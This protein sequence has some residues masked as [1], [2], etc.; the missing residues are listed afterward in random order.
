MASGSPSR[1]PDTSTS[2]TTT[3]GTPLA[4]ATSV[5]VET[6]NMRSSRSGNPG[7]GWRRCHLHRDFCHHPLSAVT[8]SGT[9][10]RFATGQKFFELPSAAE[11]HVGGG[12]AH[13]L[14][15]D[16]LHAVEVG[17]EVVRRHDHVGVERLVV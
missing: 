4:G 14:H 17:I 7:G 12:A 1:K 6:A 8:T 2:D 3:N 15:P 13:A 5:G 9:A 11:V 16:V 10:I